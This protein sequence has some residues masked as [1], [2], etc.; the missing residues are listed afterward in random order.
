MAKL[1][2]VFFLIVGLV[3]AVLGYG[4]V[5]PEFS[6]ELVTKDFYAN[7]AS[8]LIGIA[9]TV[10]LIDSLNEKR[11][12]EQAKAAKAIQEQLAEQQR[13]H[14]LIFQMG[15]P[16]RGFAVE[17]TRLLKLQGWLADG[18]VKGAILQGANLRG[19]NLEGAALQQTDLQSAILNE[20]NLRNAD[21]SE[22]NL[23]NAVIS[24]SDLFRATL[25]KASLFSARL[26]HAVLTK[27]C[28]RHADLFDANLVGA[29]LRG[30]D[31]SEADLRGADLTDAKLSPGRI[32]GI[33]ID[34][35]TRPHSF[36][37]E[38]CESTSEQFLTT[39]ES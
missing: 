15:S 9:L 22:A 27:A 36:L 29:D 7:M 5:N 30:A 39:A 19:A 12:I 1:A 17:A 24:D 20:A 2:G 38:Y 8:G 33:K 21:L 16:D 18:S 25:T 37:R 34:E 3:I 4:K 11:A 13:K 28:L 6:I 14:Q 10:L 23:K 26:D 35:R 32:K 31:L